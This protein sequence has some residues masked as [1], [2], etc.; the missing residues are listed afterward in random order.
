MDFLD[1]VGINTFLVG[2][3]GKDGLFDS[4]AI[5]AAEGLFNNFLDTHF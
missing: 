3:F 1:K 4:S 2:L 5:F